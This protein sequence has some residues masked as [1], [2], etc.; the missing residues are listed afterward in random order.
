MV[1][2]CQRT[3][4]ACRLKKEGD[5]N[6]QMYDAVLAEGYTQDELKKFQTH[7]NV[8]RFAMTKTQKIKEGM[9]LMAANP[10][11]DVEL[12]YQLHYLLD[13]ADLRF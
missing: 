11:I 8:H 1:C 13:E 10:N 9:R 6:W 5:P 2:G 7:E 3:G 12:I 4:G